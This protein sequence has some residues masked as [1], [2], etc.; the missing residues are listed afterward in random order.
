[1]CTS[2]NYGS[3]ENCR[4]EDSSFVGGRKPLGPRGQLDARLRPLREC[5]A[6][7]NM[8]SFNYLSTLNELYYGQNK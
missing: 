2:T 4:H 7:A 1:M 8:W 6:L 3:L 5:N